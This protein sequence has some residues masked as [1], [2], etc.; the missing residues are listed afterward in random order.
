[1][2]H[3]SPVSLERGQIGSLSFLL[4]SVFQILFSPFV[5]HMCDICQLDGCWTVPDVSHCVLLVHVGLRESPEGLNGS[6]AAF[7]TP[8]QFAADQTGL[9]LRRLALL[10]YPLQSLLGKLFRLIGS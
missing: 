6:E 5:I 1:M 8:H 10:I 9:Y 7:K 3:L 2:D 4:D